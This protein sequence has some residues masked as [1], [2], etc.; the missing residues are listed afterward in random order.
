MDCRTARLLLDFARPRLP[1]LPADD[2]DALEAH[3]AS[4]PECESLARA[5]RETDA[6]LGAAMRAVPIPEELRQRI[7]AGL[8]VQH[9]QWQRLWV[10]RT[11]RG[12]AAAAAIL[13]I[14]WL[15]LL[16][17]SRGPREFDPAALQE[18]IFARYTSPD[19]EKVQQW[20][21]D[22]RRV[23]T[24]APAGFNYA[25]LKYYDLTECQGRQVPYLYFTRGDAEARV[26]V[27]DR[28][29]FKLDD[30]KDGEILDSGGYHV[31][32]VHDDPDHAFVVVYKG[33][34]LQ[35]LL[36]EETAAH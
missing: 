27:L 36:N 21:Q 8:E 2:A 15:G 16:W 31:Q 33:D 14:V 34:S 23:K 20:F 7:L 13:A 35:P 9:G 6:R 3:L 1:E 10:G 22:Y 11:V 32:I 24:S 19:R 29:Q 25:C 18:D 17:Y 28:D 4:C 5:E 26:Y 12:L 30:F